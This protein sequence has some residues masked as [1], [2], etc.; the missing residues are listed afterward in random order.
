MSDELRINYSRKV[1]PLLTQ[2]NTL[3]REATNSG[4]D[5]N[6]FVRQDDPVSGKSPIVYADFFSR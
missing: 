1:A 3:L 2:V 5:V 6:V 4:I